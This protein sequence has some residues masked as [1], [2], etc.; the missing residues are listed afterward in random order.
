MPSLIVIHGVGNPSK[1]DLVAATRG[2]AL[3]FSAVPEENRHFVDW[4]GAAADRILQNDQFRW[5]S[6]ERMFRSLWSAIQVGWR[7]SAKPDSRFTQFVNHTQGLLLTTNQLCFAATILVVMLIP[8]FGI[9]SVAHSAFS[10]EAPLLRDERDLVDI[11]AFWIVPEPLVSQLFAMGVGIGLTILRIIAIIWLTSAACM[12]A[13]AAAE[14]VYYE[15]SAPMRVVVR[16]I[17]FGLFGPVFILLLLPVYDFR[18]TIT[19]F[20]VALAGPLVFITGITA[21]AFL[22][23]LPFAFQPSLFLTAASAFGYVTGIGLI[24]ILAIY[25]LAWVR[26][27]FGHVLKILL[28]ILLYAG[29]GKFRLETH[30]ALERTIATARERSSDQYFVIV[31]H[32]LGSVIALESLLTFPRWNDRDKVLL[33]TM[34]SPIRRFFQRF[35]PDY[36]FPGTPSQAATLVAARLLEYRWVNVYRPFDQIGTSLCFSPECAARDRSTGQWNVLLSAHVG[37]WND[38]KVISSLE[39]T[40]ASAGPL[41]RS[42]NSSPSASN[43]PIMFVTAG[44]IASVAL[45]PILRLLALAIVVVFTWLLISLWKSTDDVDSKLVTEQDFFQRRADQVV[46]VIATGQQVGGFEFVEGKRVPVT[47]TQMYFK[48]ANGAPIMILPRTVGSFYRR[49]M[50]DFDAAIER[51][52]RVCGRGLVA[53]FRTKSCPPLSIEVLYDQRYPYRYMLSEFSSPQT[54][55]WLGAVWKGL[56]CLLCAL[57]G[58]VLI[59]ANAWIAV[60]AAALASGFSLRPGTSK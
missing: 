7:P 24:S 23:M 9:L 29:D 2:I 39:E 25:L 4:N 35:F 8:A 1:T 36:L 17:A 38:P 46:S 43:L 3:A 14:C 30:A 60:A 44:T 48:P 32:S 54:L 47:R 20:S 57:I 33:V 52:E 28:D 45:V 59:F 37:Y 34:G 42:S 40:L 11:T 10:V 51:T 49:T 56:L 26:P 16:Q 5:A 22:I 19:M 15:S 21:V 41:P 6:V 12:V 50:F 31:A 13:I 58:S 53:P 55:S 18:P 27:G